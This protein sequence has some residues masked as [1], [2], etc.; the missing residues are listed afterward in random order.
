M[1]FTVN[2]ITSESMRLD[3]SGPQ[4]FVVWLLLFVLYIHPLWMESSKL[5]LNEEDGRHGHGQLVMDWCIGH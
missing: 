4:G 3:F 5:K 1:T 2:N